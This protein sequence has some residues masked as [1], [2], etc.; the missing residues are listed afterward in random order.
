MHWLHAT[1]WQVMTV[2]L[3]L[4]SVMALVACGFALA[5]SFERGVQFRPGTGPLGRRLLG[6]ALLA[7]VLVSGLNYFYTSRS[8]QFL[9]RWDLFHTVMTTRYFDELG[10][11]KLYE[12]AYVFDQEAGGR[13]HFAKVARIR[14][15]DTLGFV[16][17]GNLAARSD[18]DQRFS[19]ERRA[20][21]LRDLDFFFRLTPSQTK[22]RRVMTDKGYNGTP[23]YSTLV[24]LLVG[25]GPLSESRLTW[26]SLID[27]GLILIAFGFVWRSYGA[28]TAALAFVFFCV[29]F[30]NRFDHMGGSILRFDYVVFSIIAFCLMKRGRYAVAGLLLALAS[31]E[32]GFPA[33]F[34]VGLLVKALYDSV[35][36]RRIERRYLA[37][38]AGFLA[39][40]AV[41][42]ALSLTVAGLDAWSGFAANMEIHTKT[43]AGFR[44]GFQHLFMMDGNLSGPAG[45]VGYGQKA[46][47]LASHQ[48]EYYAA[49]LLFLS[50][51]VF[52]VRRV[53][54]VTF[55]ALFGLLA[56]F[57]LLVATRYYYSVLVILFLLDYDLVRERFYAV[58][59]SLAFAMT[60]VAYLVF[61]DNSFAPYVYNTLYAIML[62]GL[63]GYLLVALVVRHWRPERPERGG[64][65]PP[66]E[67]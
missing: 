3:V 54:D 14:D 35:A 66:A 10:Y 60:A 38:F 47:I 21:F 58:A 34:A 44:I 1:T 53:S 63:F 9:H 8:R 62:T 24:R 50:P 4:A 51:L 42:F 20:A 27:V 28:T 56:F 57:L 61:R 7:A 26:L 55:S 32:R 18:C 17:T 16:A 67:V 11:D 15:L 13:N 41:G 23:M 25:D 33:L 59:L 52:L 5:R 31:L 43:S 49:V 30:P 48:F 64:F 19:P 46:A 45:F 6:A 36:H 37:F 65:A 40:A 29:N 22:W 12:C 39:A 2:Q